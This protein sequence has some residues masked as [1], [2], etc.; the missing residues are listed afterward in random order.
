MAGL[1]RSDVSF[2]RS[3]SSGLVWEDK[4]L[5]GELKPRDE[6]ER[7]KREQQR[8]E[9]KPYR[10]VEVATTIDPPSPKVSG[11]GGICAMFAKNTTTTS[12]QKPTR[13]GHRKS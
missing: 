2:R 6:I 3:G 4:L 5:S 10:T 12:T 1:P 8:S 13:T 11:C 7:E 9:P